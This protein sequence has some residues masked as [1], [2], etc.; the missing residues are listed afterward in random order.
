[1]KSANHSLFRRLVLI[2][3]LV[4]GYS[5]IPARADDLGTVR[6]RMEQRLPALDQLKTKGVIGENNRGLLEL[7]G[8]DVDAG[9]AVA[10]ENRDRGLVY[11]EVAKKTGT[12]LEQVARFRARKIAAASAKGVWL[13]KDDGSWYQ[14]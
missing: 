12:S 10:A 9:D 7:R 11:A 14:K 6:A 1:M 2:A 8:G 3:A 13:Q 4:L 5:A